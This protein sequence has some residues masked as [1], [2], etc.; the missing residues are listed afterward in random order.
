MDIALVVVL[1]LVSVAALAALVWESKEHAT[2]LAEQATASRAHVERLERILASRD[3]G[4]AAAVERAYRS[5]PADDRTE[6]RKPTEVD[7]MWA[8]PTRR[9]EQ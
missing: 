6:P 5:P 9:K 3:M 1:G 8:E 4:E 2:A 7:L